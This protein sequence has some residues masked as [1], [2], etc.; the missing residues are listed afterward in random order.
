MPSFVG[1]NRQ[2]EISPAALNFNA[3][4][5][6]GGQTYDSAVFDV[7]SYNQINLEMF[8]DYTACS[9]LTWYFST[10][11][12]GGTTWHRMTTS[13]TSGGTET[14]SVHTAQMTGIGADVLIN[15]TLGGVNDTLMKITVG[16]TGGTVDTLTIRAKLGYV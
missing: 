10:S 1:F 8:L 5:I 4:T 9:A 16:N 12:D 3:R 6:V 15:Y 7:S 13:S 11:S 2:R 14:V